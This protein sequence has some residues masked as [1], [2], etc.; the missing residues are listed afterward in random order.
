MRDLRKNQLKE[1][2]S[3]L[4]RKAD[5]KIDRLK[6]SGSGYITKKKRLS[7]FIPPSV[8]S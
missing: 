6:I 8:E 2:E 5:D 3:N 4:K 1:A 7:S